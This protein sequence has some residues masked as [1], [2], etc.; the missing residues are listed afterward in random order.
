MNVTSDMIEDVLCHSVNIVN[1][2]INATNKETI[3][4]NNRMIVSKKRL[5]DEGVLAYRMFILLGCFSL[6]VNTFF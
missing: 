4:E 1:E 2:F 6:V 3:E 5:Y